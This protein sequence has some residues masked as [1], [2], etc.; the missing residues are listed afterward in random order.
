MT[1]AAG[2]AVVCAIDVGTS[3][4]RAAIVRPDGTIVRELRRDHPPAPGGGFD[5]AGRWHAL[6]ALL[7]ELTAGRD[8]RLVAAGISG[9]VGCVLTGRAGEPVI[10]GASWSDSR[11][12]DLVRRA[13]GDTSAR[14][15]Q[16]ATRRGG[17]SRLE[18][19]L[20][21]TG[22]PEP[23]GGAVPLL[24][25]LAARHP[26]AVRRVRW[27]LSPKDD[28]ILR[29]TGVAATDAT[30]AAY[31]L[32]F[33]VAA[34]DWAAELIAAAGVDPA[35]FPPVH[36]ASDVVGT[37]T[38]QAAAATG[39]PSGLPV[40][41]GGPDGTTGAAAVLGARTDVI[42][43]VA[44][45]TDVLNRVLTDPGGVPAGVAVLNPYVLPGHWS[46]GGPTGM[47]GGA[48][49]YL[50]RL[51]GLGE[52]AEPS[53]TAAMAALPPGSDGLSV[54][55][56]I[57]GARFPDWRPAERGALWGLDER[58]TPAHVLRAAQE[59]AA[60]VVRAGLDRI[61]PSAS[62][63]VLL[64]GGVARSADLCGLRADV[65]GRPVLATARPDASLLGAAL[66]ALAGAGVYADAAE[67][68]ARTAAPVRRVD[69]DPERTA[70]Y[71]ELYERWL[72]TRA[73]LP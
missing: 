40:V 46:W 73:A 18:K 33:D 42:V 68:Q 17:Q 49:A 57:S 64:A 30:S 31:T 15:G 22:R 44:G 12:I 24:A 14:G 39:L 63:P 54:V 47:T 72:R 1:C 28:L 53:L 58:H 59:G 55:P 16:E 41:A 69:P 23:S 62:L 35:L 38:A 36:D 32:G 48:V 20:R 3:G 56:L 29:L 13:W 52:L 10:E 37:V 51:L 11:G 43:D 61:D 19:A 25:W 26:E 2:E 50:L 7:R 65:T 27:A 21:V 5:P 9:H 60:Y 6:A 34:R 70:R 66:F 71:G 67:A 8:G 4:T 45:T